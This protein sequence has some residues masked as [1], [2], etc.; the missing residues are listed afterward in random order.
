MNK[1]DLQKKNYNT[2]ILINFK[3]LHNFMRKFFQKIIY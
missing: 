2:I 1:E 3:N